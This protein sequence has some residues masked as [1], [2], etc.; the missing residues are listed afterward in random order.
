[1]DIKKAKQAFSP[2]KCSKSQKIKIKQIEPLPDIIDE[3]EIKEILVKECQEKMEN[4]LQTIWE[5]ANNQMIAD[6][7]KIEDEMEKLIDNLA[8]EKLT[9]TF[10]I[11]KKY[12][13]EI[14]EYENGD[15]DLSK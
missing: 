2:K 7:N 1:L 3:E 14:K 4:N 15:C 10:E 6:L 8:T 11:N 9:K 12:E 13:Q 5:N